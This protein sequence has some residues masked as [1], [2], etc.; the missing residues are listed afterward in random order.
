MIAYEDVDKE[1]LRGEIH[2][3]L[4]RQIKAK[5][6]EIALSNW[7][8]IAALAALFMVLAIWA[9]NNYSKIVDQYEQPLAQTA[10]SDDSWEF[11][12]DKAGECRWRRTSPEGEIVGAST[13]GYR[14]LI[15]CLNNARRNGFIDQRQP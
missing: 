11:Y 15:N 12:T 3:L 7:K 4:S 5:N 6:R 1:T 13:Q 10:W 8:S 14:E 9:A 2:G